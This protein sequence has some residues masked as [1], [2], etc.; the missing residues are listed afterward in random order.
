MYFEISNFFLF[1]YNFHLHKIQKFRSI[2]QMWTKIRQL[3]FDS[4]A[5][6]IHWG[7][8]KP[9]LGI[10]PPQLADNVD[11][12]KMA[13]MPVKIAKNFILWLILQFET[14]R[15]LLSERTD[16][17]FTVPIDFIFSFSITFVNVLFF[18]FIPHV[19]ERKLHFDDNHN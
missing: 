1:Y 4:A 5:V 11:A 14:P 13:K 12:T 6:S 8:A 2:S 10:Q 3:Y 9:G 7:H 17:F 19:K 15:Q 18:G 16:D